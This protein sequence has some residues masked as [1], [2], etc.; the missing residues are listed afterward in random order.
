[1]LVLLMEEVEEVRVA[2]GPIRCQRAFDQQV[3]AS[4]VS[5]LSSVEV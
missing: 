2:L 5:F 1:M 4:E 3:E